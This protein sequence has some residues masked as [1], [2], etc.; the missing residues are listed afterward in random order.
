M[1]TTSHTPGP[2][3][4]QGQGTLLHP[5]TKRPL[6]LER[7]ETSL[8]TFE[9]FDETN[10]PDG[11]IRL[12]VAAPALLEAL[13]GARRALAKELPFLPADKEAVYCGE[14]IG[15]VDEAIALATGSNQSAVEFP[16]S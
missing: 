3:H 12:I 4:R 2:W 11:N 6:T 16:L 9:V 7:V 10:E 13:Q 5:V 8:G 14:W 1:K 15:E